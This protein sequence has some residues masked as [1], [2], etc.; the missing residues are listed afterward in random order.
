MTFVKYEKK[1]AIVVV[2]MSRPEQLN[3]MNLEM[4]DELAQ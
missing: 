4:M 3:A 2:T 1:G